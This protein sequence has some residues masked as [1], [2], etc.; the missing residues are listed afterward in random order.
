[1]SIQSS[2]PSFVRRRTRSPVATLARDRARMRSADGA[3]SS[4]G[5]IAAGIG[6]PTTS[7]AVQPK[8]RSRAGFQIGDVRSRSNACVASGDEWTIAESISDVRSSS[9]SARVARGDLALGQGERAE[10]LAVRPASWSARAKVTIVAKPAI[11]TMTGISANSVWAG[12]TT[13]AAVTPAIAATPAATSAPIIWRPR[14]L[15]LDECD[16]DHRQD[17]REREAHGREAA[18]EDRLDE[19]PVRR[20][21]EERGPCPADQDEDADDRRHDDGGQD[22]ADRRGRISEGRAEADE[23][24]RDGREVQDRSDGRAVGRG[25]WLGT[26]T[27][28]ALA[29]ALERLGHRYG[30]PPRG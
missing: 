7:S 21:A 16:A 30:T 4:S 27:V 23:Q 6:R 26:R 25:G 8:I 2:S 10:E 5:I 20:R 15:G 3:R 28:R 13:A 11:G 24:R 14:E 18:G 29:R 12:P 22:L 19:Q 9:A 1:M 17:D